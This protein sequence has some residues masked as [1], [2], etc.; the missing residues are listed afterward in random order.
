MQT[1]E[2]AMIIAI[3]RIGDTKFFIIAKPSNLLELDP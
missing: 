2:T 3:N 1:A